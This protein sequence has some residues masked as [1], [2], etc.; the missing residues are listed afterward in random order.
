MKIT[1]LN[2]KGMHC[3]ACKLLVEKALIKLPHIQTV[4][5]NV[6]KGTVKLRYEGQLN[7]NDISKV[8]LECGYEVI[9]EAV[10]HPWL[11]THI[12][13]YKIALISLAT[14]FILYTLLKQT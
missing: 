5:A 3:N 6:R 7:L 13:D 14:F 1:T 12:K 9:D 2:I 8:I 11:S 4:D 10:V